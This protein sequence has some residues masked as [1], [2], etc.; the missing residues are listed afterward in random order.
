MTVRDLSSVRNEIEVDSG[1]ALGT[2]QGDESSMGID[3]SQSKAVRAIT[4]C[5]ILVRA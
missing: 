1:A 4:S 2:T 5:V 3:G